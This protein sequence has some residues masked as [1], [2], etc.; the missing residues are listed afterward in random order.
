MS[1]PNYIQIGKRLS[2]TWNTDRNSPKG[3]PKFLESINI[4]GLRGW[5]GELVEFRYPIVAIAGENGSGK[6]TV[7]KAAASAYRSKD[8]DRFLQAKNFY[9]DDFFPN[10]PWE[11]VSGV[12]IGYKFRQGDSTVENTLRKPT[13][14]WR[15]MPERPERSTFFLDISRTQPIDTLIGYGKIAKEATFRGDEVELH[16]SSRTLLARVL[17]RSYE[18][19]KIITQEGKKVGV[20]GHEGK[21]Y[22]N[23]H[24]GA[25]EDATT[26]LVALLYD[27]PRN[28]LVIIDEVESSLH[29]RAQRRLMTELLHLSLEKRLQF[30]LSTHSPYVLEQLPTE[31]R[32][33]IETGTRGKRNL[34]YGI[35]PEFALSLMDD[36]DHSE[37]TL[38]AEDERAA[39]MVDRLISV[40]KPDIRRRV[41]IVAVGPAS[42]IAVL[43]HIASEGKFNRPA[44][45]I[46][47]A[48][49]NES[50]GCLVLPGSDAPE[51]V[52]FNSFNDDQWEKVA[53]RL[54]VRPGDML[55]S[56]E[57]AK[58]LDDCHTWP[59][60]TAENLGPRIRGS[61]VWEDCVSVWTEDNAK[62]QEHQDFIQKI[63]D[64]LNRISR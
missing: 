30:V 20:L 31:A 9:P 11:T 51:R 12:S 1:D 37:L 50:A 62:T 5:A 19:G 47:D 25:G 44:I 28:S 35:T 27:V 41:S 39:H 21:I 3:W 22:S 58:L 13:K 42:T 8:V 63:D 46:L 23:F 2:E 36:M 32:I 34:L 15:G 29:P 56:V 53:L 4:S 49:Q 54:G 60:R 55:D 6:S 16:E 18:S 43:G 52:I 45:G 48:D 33:Y 57:D 64:Y 40:H 61:R 38:Y 14:R 10:T 59:Q 24:Q 7:L 17:G 26:D